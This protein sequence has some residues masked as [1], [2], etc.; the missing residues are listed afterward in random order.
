MCYMIKQHMKIVET[1]IENVK[2]EK[3]IKEKA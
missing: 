3:I 2:E 1:Y